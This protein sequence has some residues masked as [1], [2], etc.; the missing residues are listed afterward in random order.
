MESS[1]GAEP[2]ETI[3]LDLDVRGVS[4][5]WSGDDEPKVELIGPTSAYE[6]ITLLRLA[7]KKLESDNA[8][9]PEDEE[10]DE[11]DG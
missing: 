6:A 2:A 8:L 11:D 9:S 7:Y 10:G 3:E 1:P 5:L 4:V